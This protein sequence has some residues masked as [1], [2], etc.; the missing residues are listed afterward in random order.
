MSNYMTANVI[1]KTFFSLT[2][3]A[4]IKKKEKK[5]QRKKIFKPLRL[6]QSVRESSQCECEL[7]DVYRF[8]LSSPSVFKR[9]GDE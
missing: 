2:E 5:K 4:E 8:D 7:L 6:N 3:Q 1:K 9:I